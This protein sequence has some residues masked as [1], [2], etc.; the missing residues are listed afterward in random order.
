MRVILP[1]FIIL[2]LAVSAYA[3]VVSFIARLYFDRTQEEIVKVKKMIRINET[4][5]EWLKLN[6]NGI[7]IKSYFEQNHY[8][9]IAIYGMGD[10][11]KKLFFEL[12]NSGMEIVYTVDKNAGMQ[13]KYKM[14]QLA[15]KLPKTDVII[16]TAVS[17]F[18]EIYMEL[19]NKTSAEIVNIEDMIWS[20]QR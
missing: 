7:S 16:V 11:G 14:I 15:D 8:E 1:V 10:L 17:S 12:Q 9:T 6:Q 20:I 4:L 2:F 19:K 13:D 5:S 18:N 3:A